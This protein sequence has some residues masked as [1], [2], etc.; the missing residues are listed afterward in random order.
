MTVLVECAVLVDVTGYDWMC[1]CDVLCWWNV[2]VLVG[3]VVS[4]LPHPQGRFTGECYVQMRTSMLAYLACQ[5]LRNGKKR[6]DVERHSNA[7]I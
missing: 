1:W 2:T 3:C 6:F 5:R 7:D 4:A